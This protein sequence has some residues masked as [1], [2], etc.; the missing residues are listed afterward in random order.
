[1][2]KER[3][4]ILGI[5]DYWHK[6]EFFIPFGLDQQISDKEKWQTRK[7]SVELLSLSFDDGW[8]TFSPPRQMNISGYNLYMGV[9]DKSSISSFCERH[10]SAE[11]QRTSFNIFEEDERTELDGETCFAKLRLNSQ[12]VPQLET[13]SVSALPWAL[14]TLAQKGLDALAFDSFETAKGELQVRLKNFLS[15][16]KHHTDLPLSAMEV[17]RLHEI[18]CSWAVFQPEGNQPVAVLEVIA[19]EP[20]PGKAKV[21]N[22]PDASPDQTDEASS[23]EP[24]SPHSPEVAADE[25]TEP[26]IDILNSFYIKDIE[27]TINSVRNGHVPEALRQFL[28]PGVESGRVDLFSEKGR[29]TL[30]ATLRPERMNAGHW[31]A[32]PRYAMSQRQQFAINAMRQQLGESGIFS[33]NG[34]PG[35]G[36]T[37]LLRD[38]FAENIV[39]RGRVLSN[40]RSAKDAFKKGAV[41]VSFRGRSEKTHIRPLIDELTGFEMVVA[42]SNNAAVENISVDMPKR[43]E[44]GQDWKTF[45]YLQPV[46]HNLAIVSEKGNVRSPSDQ[47]M[48]WGL[49]SCALGNSRNRKKFCD[50][51]MYDSFETPH[52]EQPANLWHWLK[53]YSGQAFEHA[54]AEF[55]KADADVTQALIARS[56]LAELALLIA[57]TDQ[58]QFL[59]EQQTASDQAQRSLTQAQ[60]AITDA[61][62]S[63]CT[64]QQVMDELREDERLIDRKR[65]GWVARLF[66]LAS[67]KA[68]NSER[69]ENASKQQRMREKI[70]LLKFDLS[71]RLEDSLQ[72]CTAASASARQLLESR[73]LEWLDLVT[74][75][76]SLIA[77]IGEP[78]LPTDLAQLEDDYFQI[79]GLWHDAAMNTLRSGLFAAALNLHQAWLAETGK[80]GGGFGGN[81][82]ALSHLLQNQKPENADHVLPIWQS[83]FMIV[84][85]ISTTFA[86]FANQFQGLG[87]NSLGWLYIDEAGQAVPQAAVGG[88]WRAKRAVIVGDPLQIEPVFTLPARLITAL[89]QVDSHTADEQ[90]APHRVSVQSLADRANAYGSYAEGEDDT[91]HWIGSPLRVHRRCLE[92]MFSLSNSIA[93]SDKMVFGLPSRT[94]A[95]AS[96]VHCDSCWIDMAGK[97]EHKQVVPQQIDF[98]VHVLKQLY[99]RDG[100]LPALFVISPFKAIRQELQNRLRRTDWSVDGQF[101]ELP[102]NTLNAWLKTHI[103]TVHTFQGREQDTVFMVLGVDAEKPGAAQ[104]AS[105]KPNLLNVALTRAKR[106]F[107]MVGDYSLW[108]SLRYF[109]VAKSKKTELALRSPQAFLAELAANADPAIWADTQRD[110]ARPD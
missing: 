15:N 9:F 84:P 107:Y 12:G 59:A 5:L 31:L 76:E 86:S 26:E 49:I 101:R 89:S 53:N 95:N 62:A 46:A 22:E 18:L 21:A 25:E 67:A 98:M 75:W 104:W 32:D 34:P 42:S 68:Y 4:R 74:E 51:V 109:N 47:D 40:L 93:Y 70:A 45:S 36:K 61:Q 37:T 96:P 105:S 58:H 82:F 85:V 71:N 2:D 28:M 106:R 63:L 72:G 56:R 23:D 33:V 16:R 79:H 54:A 14:G 81:I 69:V 3:Q 94:A 1:M 57:Q 30:F 48:P 6:I 24:V 100:A 102:A 66:N 91:L 13:V 19:H 92:P 10:I 88:L 20:R 35:T 55:R 110:G 78:L 65:P 60:T 43:K 29:Q 38:L 80:K 90:Y 97:T 99:Q 87:P 64:E 50:R 73:R 103:G 27:R 108:S 83:L 41:S 7:L 52:P 8:R 77:Q 17:L 11:L 39:R 44:L